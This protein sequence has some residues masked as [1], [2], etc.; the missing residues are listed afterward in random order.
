MDNSD[1][2]YDRRKHNRNN[3]YK[4]LTRRPLQQALN[5]LNID[6]FCKF[7]LHPN[8]NPYLII[9]EGKYL[10]GLLCQAANELDAHRHKKAYIKLGY[11]NVK[12]V[13]ND[14]AGLEAAQ[15]MLSNYIQE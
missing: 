15:K 8:D 5:N 14:D 12:V 1:M 6:R 3:V 7:V 9:G 2:I 10:A 11:K 13:L 4:L